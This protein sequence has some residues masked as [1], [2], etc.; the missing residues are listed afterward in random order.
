MR[1]FTAKTRVPSSALHLPAILFF[2]KLALTFQLSNTVQNPGVP[3]ALR[4]GARD[5]ACRV[6]AFTWHKGLD[7]KAHG[8]VKPAFRQESVKRKGAKVSLLKR[9]Q[10]LPAGFVWGGAT[11]AY[12]VEGNTHADGRGDCLW[13]VYLRDGDQYTYNPEP[14]CD[15]YHRYPEDIEL[16]STYGLNAIRVSISWTRIFPNGDPS[17]KPNPA[18]ITY[19][20]KLFACCLEHGV[21]PYVT[22][23]HFD[24]PQ[25]MVERGDWLNRENID[26]FVGYARFCF[27][28]FTEVKNWF[29]INEL[30]SLA[31]AQYIRGVFPPARTF[32]VSACMQ[33]QHNELLAHARVVN[34]Y[35]ELELDGRIGLIHVLKPIYPIDSASE[36]VHAAELMDAINNRF[37]LDGTFLGRYTDETMALIDEICAAND[38]SFTIEP[39]DLEELANAAP[40]ND[41]FGLNYY[42]P[43]FVRAYNGES[44]A[45][46][47]GTG[48]KGTASFRFKGVCES[49]SKPGIP[50]TDWDWNIYPRGLYDLLTRVAADYPDYPITYITENG[51]GHKDPTP[52][53]DGIVADP[54]RIDFVDQHVEAVLQARDEGVNV[55]GYFI[56][57]LQ[58]QFS[59]SNGYNKRYGLFYVDFETQKRYVKTSALWYRE[60]ADTMATDAR[61]A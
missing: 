47:N 5:L 49:V 44:E 40:R 48:D 12:Q 42:Q 16:A 50:T 29:T 52:G 24:S 45:H 4:P 11:A 27:K 17:A 43:Q 6:S 22:L 25:T 36:N 60:L 37:L 28:E 53:P 9:V 19:Y 54:E 18:G 34:L 14:A 10:K 59:W 55:Q 61:E 26:W 20:H 1:T 31:M 46:H 32:D 33:A 30:I 58:D 13:D 57:S 8:F 15:F 38:A 51:L 41:M 7:G 2:K 35:K 39:G 23:H 21:E 56:W 3:K